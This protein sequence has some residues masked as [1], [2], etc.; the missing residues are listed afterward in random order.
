[1]PTDNISTSVISQTESLLTPLTSKNSEPV[2]SSFEQTLANEVQNNDSSDAKP[3]STSPEKP[4]IA[5]F[6]GWS[7]C[8]GLTIRYATRFVRA[9]PSHHYPLGQLSQVEYPGKLGA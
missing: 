9:G 3:S 8:I 2:G 6:M 1:M 5:Q 7:P 4:C